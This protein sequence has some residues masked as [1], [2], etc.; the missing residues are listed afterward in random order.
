MK[1]AKVAVA[2]TNNK[3]SQIRYK[4]VRKRVIVYDLCFHYDFFFH[5][6]FVDYRFFFG[7]FFFVFE[8][9]WKFLLFA[10][11]IYCA[12]NGHFSATPSIVL[13][14]ETTLAKVIK[15]IWRQK[16][17]EALYSLVTRQNIQQR[18]LSSSTWK[19]EKISLGAEHSAISRSNGWWYSLGPM[20]AVNSFERNRPLIFF[21]ISFSSATQEFKALVKE[22]RKKKTKKQLQKTFNGKKRSQPSW[23]VINKYLSWT[24]KSWWR[25]KFHRFLWNEKNS[26]VNEEF[27]MILQFCKTMNWPFVNSNKNP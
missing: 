3:T 6:F 16:V 26:N 7:C 11:V 27:W 12:I 25:L 20:M 10:L 4:H 24:N 9:T 2:N 18:T 15:V 22:W 1:L 17:F 5:S 8:S 14:L 13:P 21:K 23:W 19:R